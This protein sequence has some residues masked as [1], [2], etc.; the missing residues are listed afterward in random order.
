MSL[1]YHVELRAFPHVARA[2]N[3]DRATLDARFVTPLTAG[4]TLRYEDRSWPPDKTRLKVLEAERPLDSTAFGLGR[5]WGEAERHARDV[6][7]AILAQARRGA[8]AR[9]A[10]DALKNAITAAAREPLRCADAAA[11]AVD[12][13]PQRRASEQLALAEQAVW[14]LLHER[15][16]ELLDGGEPVAPERWREV[17]LRWATWTG[18]DDGDVRL[19][20]VG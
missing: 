6:T 20:A 14:E 8:D 19:R 16:L 10:L 5:G 9:P 18:A 1:V 15:R 2:F 7:D 17:V 3:L 11:L 13:E 4:Q 12:A